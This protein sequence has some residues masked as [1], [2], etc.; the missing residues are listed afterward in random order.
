MKKFQNGWSEFRVC[1][2]SISFGMPSGP[3]TFLHFRD[4][5]SFS[6]SL[7]LYQR[8]V[9]MKTT[10][11]ITSW[12]TSTSLTRRITV[13][14]RLSASPVSTHIHT[15]TTLWPIRTQQVTWWEPSRQHLVAPRNRLQ[16]FCVPDVLCSLHGQDV[17][18]ALDVLCSLFSW[19]SMCTRCSTCSRFSMSSHTL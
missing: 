5:S 17:L 12:L 6:F 9:M 2:L 10:L 1:V 4:F 8:S 7:S 14:T 11:N 13:T 3:Q 18:W 16:M 15:H 19:C